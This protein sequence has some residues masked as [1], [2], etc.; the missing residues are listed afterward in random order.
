MAGVMQET[1]GIYDVSREINEL[2]DDDAENVYDH[3]TNHR[4]ITKEGNG[5]LMEKNETRLNCDNIYDNS[6][7]EKTPAEGLYDHC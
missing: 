4:Q 1:E 6:N 2:H 7:T 3:S 5:V